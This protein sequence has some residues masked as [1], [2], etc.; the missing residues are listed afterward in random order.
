MLNSA[1]T[2]TFASNLICAAVHLV[3]FITVA[4]HLSEERVQESVVRAECPP[5]Q[6]V[7]ILLCVRLQVI[8]GCSATLTDAETTKQK[9]GKDQ[10]RIGI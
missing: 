4:A 6:G 8:N 1:G 9:R 7:C 5:P 3:V 2:P 10:K